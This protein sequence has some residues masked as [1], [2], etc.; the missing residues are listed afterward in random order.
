MSL[1]IMNETSP[2]NEMTETEFF[3]RGE[4]AQKD[5]EC[6]LKNRTKE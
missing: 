3:A 5:D 4:G 1:I 2:S 6:N